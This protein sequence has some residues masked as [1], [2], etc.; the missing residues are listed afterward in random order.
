MADTLL[1][2]SAPEPI[3]TNNWKP[4]STR[5]TSASSNEDFGK[6]LGSLLD[7][8]TASSACL[9]FVR[10]LDGSASTLYSTGANSSKVGSS[11]I[12][13]WTLLPSPPT[14]P[15][16]SSSSSSPDSKVTTVPSEHMCSAH[17]F[18]CAFSKIP[19]SFPCQHQTLAFDAY[20]MKESPS[21]I[22]ST[23]MGIWDILSCFI[24]PPL[25]RKKRGLSSVGST[26]LKPLATPP[27]RYSNAV[28]V[29]NAS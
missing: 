7:A 10:G 4:V 15:Q 23:D 8:D 11:A 20:K 5:Y 1:L 22:D 24:L 28:P 26:W 6:H 3:Q 25:T 21:F 9:I 19:A 17:L 18:A 27:S 14:Y 29:G 2:M 12:A 13:A 16:K